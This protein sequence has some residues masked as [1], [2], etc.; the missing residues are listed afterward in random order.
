MDHHYQEIQMVKYSVQPVL[1]YNQKIMH[2]VNYVE[3]HFHEI[4]YHILY[5]FV[6]IVFV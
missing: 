2:F 3:D 6:I 4:L 1:F 5:L